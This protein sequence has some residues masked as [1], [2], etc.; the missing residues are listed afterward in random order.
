MATREEIK[1]EFDKWI[2]P[3]GLMWWNINLV[4]YDDPSDVVSN[5]M[6]D[7]N[8]TLARVFAD[9][10]YST[11]SVHINLIGMA[12]VPSDEVER[13]ALHELVH[14]LVNEMRENEMHHEERVVT[15]L[16]NAF[17]WTKIEFGTEEL[18]E[19]ITDINSIVPEA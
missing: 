7:D 19:H 17:L 2:K 4:Y 11:A 13:I 15:G 12:S 14:I 9:W 10:R 8:V 16:T 6:E 5:F 18:D 3:L 1:A